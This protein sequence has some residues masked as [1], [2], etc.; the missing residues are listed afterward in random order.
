LSTV[1]LLGAVGVGGINARVDVTTVQNLINQSIRTI[2]PLSVL[3]VTGVCDNLTIEAITQFQRRVARLPAPDGRV[4]P[5]GRT[6]KALVTTAS[7]GTFQ[8]GLLPYSGG[9][10]MPPAL[11]QAPNSRYT[12]SPNEVVTKNTVPLRAKQWWCFSRLIAARVFKRS[13]P[14][15]KAPRGGWDIIRKSPHAFQS[16][17]PQPTTG[18]ASTLPIC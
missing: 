12:G 6:L 14:W 18:T 1:K 16:S 15:P 3:K 17:C 8:P 4:D 10:A 5:G 7:G 13:P 2:T 9:S 11:A